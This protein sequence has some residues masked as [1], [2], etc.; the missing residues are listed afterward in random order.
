MYFID[1]PFLEGAFISRRADTMERAGH[2]GVCTTGWRV[3]QHDCNPCDEVIG[4]T[5][6]LY[7][8]SRY[9]DT[10]TSTTASSRKCLVG[11]FGGV[12]PDG[13]Q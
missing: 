11:E 3:L 6:V 7:D 5:N 2:V 1:P 9:Q 4:Q 13:R 8:P 12:A 10:A